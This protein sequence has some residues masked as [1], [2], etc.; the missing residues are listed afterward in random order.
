MPTVNRCDTCQNRAVYET[1]G[2][3]PFKPSTLR[4][5][6]EDCFRDRFPVCP[7]CRKPHDACQCDYRKPLLPE[8]AA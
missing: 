2:Q 3:R 6:C 4:R 1:G 5:F 8:P 7:K